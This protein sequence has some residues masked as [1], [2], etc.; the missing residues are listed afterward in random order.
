MTELFD[1]PPPSILPA[2]SSPAHRALAAA[3]PPALRFGTMS[4]SYP[5]WTG[6]VYGAQLTKKQ[7]V[8]VGLTAY[9]KHPLLRAVELDRGYY[10]PL[11]GSLLQSF[12]AQVPGD[13][14]FLVKAHE[15]C[16]V[17]TF[18][19]HARYGKQGGQ[20][21]PRYLDAAFADG[22]IVAPLVAGL[23]AKLGVLL[24]Q[25][26]PDP[27]D[28]ADFAD[29]LHGF[30]R[31]LPKGVPYAVEVRNSA[32]LNPAYAAALRDTGVVHC[33]NAWTTMPS[34]LAQAR[35]LPPE[36]RR[37]LVVRWLLPQGRSYE[38][39]RRRVAPLNRLVDDDLERRDAIAELVAKAQR[40]AVP[41]FV[42]V[43][44]KAEGCAPLSIARLA[45]D[46]V[47]RLQSPPQ[48]ARD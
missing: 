37:P 47:E 43:D 17:H 19:E 45:K 7:L 39:A 6:L 2:P 46:I 14:R 31:R 10:E 33:H 1:L 41:T 28:P 8:D 34:V 25:F 32:R 11:D 35:Q 36:S 18:P 42:F 40:H 44:N 38:D 21:N 22:E 30:L 15:A 48:A 23:G 16:T 5:G 9:A 27:G 26:S 29:R 20:R 3:L 4:W 13:F 12:A 24:F